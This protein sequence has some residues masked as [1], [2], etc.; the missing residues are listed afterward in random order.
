ME[1][2]I[3]TIQLLDNDGTLF[4]N[5]TTEADYNK[6]LEQPKWN[7]PGVYDRSGYAAYAGKLTKELG[8]FIDV[9]LEPFSY[10]IY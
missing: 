7:V 2:L 5:I 3:C 10:T 1:N 4:I 8:A 9:Q 6:T